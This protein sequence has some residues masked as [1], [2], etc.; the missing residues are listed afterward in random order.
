MIKLLVLCITFL[1]SSS[2][3]NEQYDSSMAD[4]IKSIYWVSNNQDNAVVYA[5]WE[6]FIL[7][8]NLIDNTLLSGE[9]V[10]GSKMNLDNYE[11]LLIMLPEQ[12]KFLAIYVTNDSFIFDGHSYLLKPDDL[13]KIR[14][15]NEYRINKGDSISNKM[16]NRAKKTFGFKGP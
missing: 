14:K 13:N 6:G 16:L 7:L 2:F 9:P 5:K 10:D 15:M 8:K 11:Q 4:K 1:A 3:A 12:K